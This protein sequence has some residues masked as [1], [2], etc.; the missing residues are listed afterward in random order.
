MGTILTN[1]YGLWKPTL[2]LAGSTKIFQTAWLFKNE[3][4]ASASGAGN[5]IR[6]Y[7]TVSGAPFF[8]SNMYVGYTLASTET[9]VMLGGVLTYDL[10]STAIVGTKTASSGTPINTSV[11]VKKNTGVVGKRYRGRS[12]LPNMTVPELNISQA[13]I[14]DATGLAIVQGQYDQLFTSWSL[15][16]YPPY[17]GHSVSEIAPTLIGSLTVNPKVG[18][19]PHRIRGF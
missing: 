14:I 16:S 19:M 8:A 4:S 9:Y 1:G 2:T 18:S 5:T 17:L 11:I 13:G 15:S 7:W 3:T 6:G 12:M 10:N